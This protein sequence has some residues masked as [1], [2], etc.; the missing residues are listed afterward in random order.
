MPTPPDSAPTP[1]GSPTRTD[2]RPGLRPAGASASGTTVLSLVMCATLLLVACGPTRRDD[3]MLP[4]QA[5]QD[6]RSTAPAVSSAV[7]AAAPLPVPAAAHA[8]APQAGQHSADAERVPTAPVQVAAAPAAPAVWGRITAIEPIKSDPVAP[9]GAGLVIGGVL[10]GVLGHQVG[11][12]DGRK[13]A[14]VLGAV[15]GAVAG[16]NVEKNS[17]RQ[18]VGFRVQVQL[19]SGQTRSVTLRQRGDFDTGDRVRLVPGGLQRS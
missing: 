7:R 4:T 17:N 3:G 16:N 2:L 15:G 14:T 12:G 19:D 11:G 8:Q 13:A 1:A 6:A 5:P 10:G 9:S 18:V